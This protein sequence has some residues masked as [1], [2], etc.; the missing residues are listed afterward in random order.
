MAK[1]TKKTKI[2]FIDTD[3]DIEDSYCCSKKN[4]PIKSVLK[5]IEL[6]AIEVDEN[7]DI[8]VSNENISNENVIS[9]DDIVIFS[10]P[11]L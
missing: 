6:E 2:T 4:P 9:C 11:L 10:F 7:C 1:D 5:E 3:S 8:L